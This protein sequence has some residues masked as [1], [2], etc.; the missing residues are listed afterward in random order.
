MNSA[1]SEEVRA[2]VRDELGI[3]RGAKVVLYAPTWR[4]DLGDEQALLGSRSSSTSTSWRMS[5]GEDHVSSCGASNT[6]VSA[7]PTAGRSATDV[8]AHPDISELFLAADVLVTDYS[9]VMFDFA[10]TGKPDVLFR[11][12]T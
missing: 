8:S 12:T 4:D 7:W 11:P 1:G 2:R 5:L 3:P 9:S 10:V 6:T